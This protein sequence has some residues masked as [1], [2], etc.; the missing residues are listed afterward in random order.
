VLPTLSKPAF[1]LSFAQF[2]A[3]RPVFVDNANPIPKPTTAP[4][5]VP[6][7][8]ITD[9]AD[10]PATIVPTIELAA[11]VP[12]ATPPATI[13]SEAKAVLA[14]AMSDF[15]L[16]LKALELDISALKIIAWPINPPPLRLFEK[17]KAPFP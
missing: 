15:L 11:V 2:V 12:A 16:P 5:T 4:A 14:Y 9:P 6:A 13:T 8:G 3:L 7:P 10:E 17:F 1:T